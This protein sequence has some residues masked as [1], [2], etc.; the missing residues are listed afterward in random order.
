MAASQQ[1]TADALWRNAALIREHAPEAL[2]VLSADA[3]YA[4]DYG[5]LVE[6]H[7]TA[8]RR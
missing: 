6:Q 3:V 2:V 8:T 5:A 7:M 4:Q 1:G